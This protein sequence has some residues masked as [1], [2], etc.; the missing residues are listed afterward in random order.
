[1]SESNYGV[2]PLLKLKEAAKYLRIH[3]MT[4]RRIV[5]SGEIP[6]IFLG[7]HYRFHKV[8]LDKWLDQKIEDAS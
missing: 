3:E 2:A 4:L 7:K 1:M 5:K 8:V 6:H